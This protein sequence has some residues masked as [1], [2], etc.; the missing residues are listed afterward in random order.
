MRRLFG[1]A[2][3]LLAAGSSLLATGILL[4]AGGRTATFNP[5]SGPNRPAEISL[6]LGTLMLWLGCTGIAVV[7]RRSAAVLAGFLTV[8]GSFILPWSLHAM[9]VICWLDLSRIAPWSVLVAGCIQ[10]GVA[11]IR[12]VMFTASRVVPAISHKIRAR[13]LPPHLRSVLIGITLGS[14][15]YF[16]IARWYQPP[17]TVSFTVPVGAEFEWDSMKGVTAFHLRDRATKDPVWMRAREFL[18]GV[19]IKPQ[20]DSFMR[21]TLYRK[22]AGIAGVDVVKIIPFALPGGWGS[23]D[24]TLDYHISSLM[25]SNPGGSGTRLHCPLMLQVTPHPSRSG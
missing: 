25:R 4:T 10:V 13:D 17:L 2:L 24:L 9:G 19:Q 21:Q 12:T 15:A 23:G 5:Y 11:V 8:A 7:L 1:V 18:I 16:W 3:V 22:A 14:L 6:L 20:L